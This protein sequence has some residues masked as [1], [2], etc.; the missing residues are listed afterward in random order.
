M[1]RVPGDVIYGLTLD[2][3]GGMTP[4]A[5]GSE[6]PAA[7][8]SWVHL[9][10]GNPEAARWLL[11]TPLL[12]DAARESLL[13]QSN[14]PKLVRMGETVLLILREAFLGGGLRRPWGGGLR[15]RAAEVPPAALDAFRSGDQRQRIAVERLV[16]ARWQA[17]RRGQQKQ[18]ASPR[19]QEV[20]R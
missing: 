16:I 4:L 9:D 19:L 12:N 14:R 10:Y 20:P 5:T 13:G 1:D 3:K 8:P 17:L 6:I 7:Q 11:Q 18:W 15:G 2:G